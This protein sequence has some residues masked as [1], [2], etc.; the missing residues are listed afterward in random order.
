MSVPDYQTSVPD[1]E[2]RL[3]ARQSLVPDPIYPEHAA[4]AMS[5]FKRLRAVDVPG[6]PTY[7]QCTATELLRFVQY[8]FGAYDAESG[9]NLLKEILLLIPKKNSKST[10]ASAIMLT[11]LIIGWRK[12]AIY[13]IVAPTIEIAQASFKPAADSVRA[14]PELSKLINISTHTKTLTNRVTGA[15]LKVVAAEENTV[16][17][18]KASVLL[19]DEAH[20]FGLRENGSALLR[21][22]AGGLAARPEGYVLKLSTQSS[23]PPAGVFKNDLQMFRNIRDGVVEDK[24]RFALMFE[25]P[26][27]WLDSGRAKTVEGLELVNPSLGYSVDRNFLEDAMGK[28][29]QIGGAEELD[30]WAKFGNIELGINL[31]DDR[32][33]GSDYWL[34]TADKTLTLDTLIERCEVAVVGIDGGGLSDLLGLSV[35]GRCKKTRRWLSWSHGWAHSIV[36]ERI[37]QISSRL[38]D[39]E[40]DGDL[41]IVDLPGQDIEQLCDI[42]LKLE[43]AGILPEKNAIG[44]DAAGISAIIDLLTG[45]EYNIDISRIV[46]VAQGYRL[47][48]AIKTTER[49]LAGN[50]LIHADQDIMTWNISNVKI[51]LRG[52]A[53]HSTKAAA[54]WAKVDL[55]HALFNAVSLISLNP[56]GRGTV[57]DF[58]K[59]F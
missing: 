52:S 25:H 1:W 37:K 23:A 8:C 29:K 41:T 15:V 19:I 39:F 4:T 9:N 54:G 44:V 21:E 20:L 2:Q 13:M 46:A 34:Q 43:K 3:E 42:V 5:V 47:S 10:I 59:R 53:L 38:K 55:V 49:A 36:L 40:R 33:G 17:G 31:R 35:V 12:S 51:E 56:A 32:F 57:E 11:H 48:G 30:F 7:G 22:A 6:S 45:P 58:L 24:R 50:T 27:S 28:A 26:R 16:T 14:D 18:S